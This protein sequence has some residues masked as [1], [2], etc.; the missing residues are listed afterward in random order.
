M[1]EMIARE[2]AT[3]D[4]LFAGALR[5]RQPRKGHRAGTDGVL[6]A[7]ITPPDARR[8]ADMGAST[9]LV[10]LRA[11]QLN[12]TARVTLIEQE[13]D[14]LALARL[15]IEENN[16]QSRVDLCAADVLTLGKNH[17]LREAFDAVLS[18]PPYFEARNVRVSGDDMRMKAHVFPAQSAGLEGWIKAAATLTAPHGTCT[19]IYHIEALN[20]LLPAFARRFGG[21]IITPVHAKAQEA[22]IRVLVSGIKGSR[23]PLRLHPPLIL[24]EADGCFTPFA[25]RLHAGEARLSHAGL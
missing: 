4:T 12:K 11:A 25:A 19:F 8:I 17:D 14:L 15:N 24:H 16:L 5:L 21:V 7:A 20:A 13:T 1:N 6:L 23:A 10:G 22:A 9:G 3:E 18:N 2:A